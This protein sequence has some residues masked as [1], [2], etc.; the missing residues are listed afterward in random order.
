MSTWLER[1]EAW[2]RKGMESYFAPADAKSIEAFEQHLNERKLP[3]VVEQ[4]DGAVVFSCNRLREA[5]QQA[6]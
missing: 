1:E 4:R 6:A 2:L 5:W 3:Y